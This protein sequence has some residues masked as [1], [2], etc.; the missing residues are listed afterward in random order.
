MTAYIRSVIHRLQAAS[1]LFR[2]SLKSP[3]PFA[4]SIDNST[5]ALSRRFLLVFPAVTSGIV[6]SMV[7][8][9]L[10]PAQNLLVVVVRAT[11]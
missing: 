11:L 7:H 1:A 8:R 2:E 9:P 3:S 10:G 4:K 6:R 5:S